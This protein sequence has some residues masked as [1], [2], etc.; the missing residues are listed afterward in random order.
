MCVCCSKLYCLDA[1]VLALSELKYKKS[2]ENFAS[3]YISHFCVVPH[4]VRKIFLIAGSLRDFA[5]AVVLYIVLLCLSQQI[6]IQSGKCDAA[7]Q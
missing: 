3:F 1:K 5:K 4:Y 2:G 7:L 6:H